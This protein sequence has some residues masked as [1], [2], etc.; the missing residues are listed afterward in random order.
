MKLSTVFLLF[1]ISLVTII[2]FLPERVNSQICTGSLGDAVVNVTFGS[3][4]N[5]GNRLPG[6]TTNYNFT[7]GDCPN[8]GSYTVINGTNRCFGNS[9]HT[10]TEDHTPNDVN[11]YMMLVNASFTPSDFYVDTVRNLCASTTYEFGAWITNVILPTACIPNLIHPRLV[12]NIETL[13]GQLLGTYSTGE[14]L[15]TSSAQ[16]KQ[17]GLFFTTPTNTSDVVIRLTNNAPGGCG[18]DLALDDITFRPCGPIISAGSASTSQKNIEL[19]IDAVIPANLSATLGS[20]FISPSLQWQQSIDNGVNWTDISGATT[21]SYLFNKTTVGT[22]QYRLSAA[23]GPNI[24]ITNCRVA[25]N[26]VTI[27][28]HDLPVVTAGNNGPLCENGNLQLAASGGISYSWTG[29]GGFTSLLPNPSFTAQNNA[30]GTYNVLVKDS[31]GCSNTVATTAIINPNPTAIVSASQ[32]FCEG[33]TIVLSALGGVSYLWSPV[34]GL[35]AAVIANPLAYPIQTTLYKVMVTDANGCSDSDSVTITI[36]KKPTA[37]AGADKIIIKGATVLLEGVA[38]GDDIDF[39]W[40][41]ADFITDATLLNTSSKPQQSIEYTLQV[42]SN[43]G[44][45]T[46]TDAMFIKVYNDLYIP[47]AFSPNNDGRNDTWRMEALTAYPNAIVSIYNRLGQNV[48]T[49]K[50]AAAVWNGIFKGNPLPA[51]SYVYVIDLKNGRALLKGTVILL[52]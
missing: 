10:L 36:Y 31:F 35:S 13:T 37:A 21:T 26:P 7:S 43:K 24:F 47:T 39:L 48:Y 51:G 1:K 33:D 27:T 49:G 19:C 18:N 4:A 16:W 8:D 20:G 44:C 30:T 15:A 9:W 28:I 6:A 41:P 25:S 29:P 46:A 40:T 45:G 32:N 34:T 3:G 22:Y 50:G 14:I 5:P 42:I 11:G 2:A 52:R 38:S 12:F 17:Y 23:E